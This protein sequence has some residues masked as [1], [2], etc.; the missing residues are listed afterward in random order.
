MEL[1]SIQLAALNAKL[2]PGFKIEP[3]SSKSEVVLP[4]KQRRSEAENLQFAVRYPSRHAEK[5]PV[6]EKRP[7]TYEEPE[8]RPKQGD[9]YRKINK[10]LQAMKR[11]PM[12]EPFLKPVDSKSVPDYYDIITH[13]MD[14][15]TAEHKLRTGQYENSFS[16]GLDVRR[17]WANSYQYNH[18]DS[19]IYHMTSE[20]SSL[21]EK[22]FQGYDNLNLSD[23]KDPVQELYRK[24]ERMSNE[25][26]ELRAQEPIKTAAKTV[27][28][29]PMT[30][31]EKK[32]LGQNIRKLDKKDLRGVYEIVKEN[33][34]IK[35]DSVEF[36]LDTL[37][38]K[39]CRELERY[40]KQKLATYAKQK[41]KEPDNGREKQIQNVDSQLEQIARRTRVEEPRDLESESSSSTSES[42]DE[43]MP[44]PPVEPQPEPQAFNVT[45]LWDTFQQQRRQEEDL[46]ANE[47]E[48]DWKHSLF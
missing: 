47:Y 7:V 37:P 29:K 12:A 26:R 16:F 42:E 48:L 30:L 9:A 34:E 24:V 39:V 18:K 27:P 20:L 1:T 19:D 38:A 10:I 40:V 17:I 25:L 28:E 41:K 3:V 35:H 36:D 8:Y 33:M 22:L 46:A 6:R 15:S 31:H 13:P 45:S 11:H 32:L 43:E 4:T 2:P 23:K 5:R 21:F 44:A 14:L